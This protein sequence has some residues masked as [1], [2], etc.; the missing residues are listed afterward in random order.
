MQ[1]A[2]ML[3]QRGQHELADEILRHIQ[4]SNAYQT[5]AAQDTLRLAIMT[6]AIHSRRHQVVVEQA[7]KLINVHQFN[8]EPVRI[9]LACLASGLHQTDAFI[10]SPFQKHMLREVKFAD[11]AINHREQLRWN[12][13]KRRFGVS[14]GS[15]T[16]EDDDD[17]AG[18]EHAGDEES[19]QVMDLPKPPTKPN[20]NILALYGQ[21]CITAKSYQSAIFYLLQA[22]EHC[23]CDPVICLCLA[24]SSVGRAMQRQADNRH[25]LITQGL[26]FLSKYR[27]IRGAEIDDVDF[28]FGRLFH[29]L[30]LFSNAARHYERVLEMAENRMKTDANA[31]GLAKEAAYNLSLI[32]VTTGAGPL[33]QKLYRQWLS[34]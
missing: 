30:G 12:P 33:A 28:N 22:Y 26:A 13:H 3:A 4:C 31:F 17:D 5:R 23:P 1:Y 6:C 18:E 25:H 29:Q 24:I 27:D 11:L 19:Q 15:K 7:R 20:P 2:F 9:L 34:L 10:A 21:F 32:Y 16:A 8:N 14:G